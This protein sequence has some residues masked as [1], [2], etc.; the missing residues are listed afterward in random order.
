MK[1]KR[2]KEEE[3]VRILKESE[4]AKSISELCR[5]DGVA[6]VTYYRWRAKCAG[7]EV[8]EFKRAAVEG[9]R[10]GLF[11]P[12]QSR[13]AVKPM[14][15]RLGAGECISSRRVERMAAMASS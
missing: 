4:S 9:P 1:Q 14:A 3:I 15:R 13:S 10:C 6:D 8:P 7:M 2:F 11:G 5:K 12:A